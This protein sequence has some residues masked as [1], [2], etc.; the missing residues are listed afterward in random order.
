M[1]SRRADL[2]LVPVLA[3]FAAAPFVVDTFNLDVLTT[4]VIYGLM[5]MGLALLVG[6]AGLPSLGHAA[7]VGVGGYTSALLALRVSES[8][9][10]GLLAAGLVGG[11]LAM[12]LGV[13]SLRSQGV[14]FL[15]ISLALAELVHA[16]AIRNDTL[17]GDNGLSIASP[18]IPLLGAAGLPRVVALYWYV[19]AIAVVVYVLLRVVLAT[20]AGQAI[21][22][23]KDNA[24]RMRALGYS[25]RALRMVALVVSGVTVAVGGAL[26]TQKDVFISPSALSPQTSILL[27]VM[28][29]VGGSTS[30]LGPFLAGVGLVLLRS[31]ISSSLGAYWV[32]V[33]GVVFVLTVYLM[34]NGAAGLVRRPRTRASTE[35]QGELVA[36]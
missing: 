18:P 13:M 31:Y 35:R 16:T 22:G 8:P 2:L 12:L 5:A 10:L 25:V 33:L 1:K 15:M 27:L 21:L 3:A 29:L 7:F 17:G 24:E 32:L 11:L 6:Q 9:L 19:L 34:P 14:Y 30:L 4:G 26:L 36:D 23:S 20:P 28:V